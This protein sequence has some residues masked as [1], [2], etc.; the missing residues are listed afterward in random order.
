M[1]SGIGDSHQLK[2]H[3]ITPFVHL[4]G[5]GQSLQ[6]HPMFVMDWIMKPHFSTRANLLSNPDN[7]TAARKQLAADGTGPLAALFTTMGMGYFR[8]D[9]LL[10]HP[11]FN[12]LPKSEQLFISQPNVPTWEIVTMG[13][14]LNPTADP[15]STYLTV[16]GFLQSVQSSGSVTLA[17]NNPSDAPLCD[18]NFLNSDFDKAN[19]VATLREMVKFV[20]TPL[21]AKDMIESFSAPS[22]TST[23][24]ELMAWARQNTGAT[25]HPSCT[26]KMGKKDDE[27]ACVDNNFKVFGLQGLRVADMS[28]SPFMMN[29][30]TQSVAY[31][32]GATCAEKLVGEYDLDA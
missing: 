15:S 4:P 27:M 10:K 17:S 22:P 32:I 26:A 29:C 16:M 24:E 14:V 5:I 7:L 9:T 20:Q 13:P 11:T 25:W 8:N 2:Q 1:L 30:H 6:D 18:P 21:I 19:M 3:N 23:D 31:W 28:V 12:S